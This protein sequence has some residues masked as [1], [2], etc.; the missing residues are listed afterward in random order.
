MTGEMPPPETEGNGSKQHI[1]VFPYPAQGH[2][3]PL[4]DLTHQLCLRADITVSIIVTPKNLPYISPLLTAHPSS[5]SAVTFPFPQSPSLPPGV[6][7]VKDIG[8]SGNPLIMASIRQLREPIINWLSSHPNPPVAI[9][10]DFFLGWTNDL[11]IP[12]FAFFSSGAFLASILHFF[13]DKLHLYESTEPVCFSDL[14]RSPVFK[15]EHIPSLIPESPSLQD[16]ESQ[17]DTMMNFS[18]YGCV[19]NSCEVLEEEY[20]EYVKLKTGHNRVYGVG[21]LSSIGLGKGNSDSSV[22]V[23]ALMSWLDGCL[24]GSVLYI[25]FGSQKVLNKDQCDALALG[26]EKSMTRFIWVAKTDPIPDGFEDRVAG[27]GIV[28]R[29]W[30][31]QV[32]VL[33]HVAVGGFLSHCGWNS[34]MEAVA[35]GTMILAWPMGADQYVDA[36]LLVE[37]KGVA[38][39][40]CE[41]GDTVPNPYELGRALAETMGECGRSVRDRANKMGHRALAATEPGGSSDADLER[42]VIEL[43]CL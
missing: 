17:R 11:G 8:P 14:P 4:L 12:R 21:P 2:L 35:S 19:F 34:V 16:L 18:S 31:P 40:V 10:S 13:S 30:A 5:I 26:L 38:V 43:S 6:E 42:L 3:L 15:I 39:M 25:C 24:H 36:R 7:N 9:I 22:D 27:R 20:M 32:A 41:G 29:G 1:M 33:S 28:V 23:E 37:H